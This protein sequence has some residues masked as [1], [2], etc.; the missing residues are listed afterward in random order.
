MTSDEFF[1]QNEKRF[2][3]IFIDGLHEA[4]QV[5]R[6]VKNSLNYLNENG[7]ILLH[8]CNPSIEEHQTFP[9]SLDHNKRHLNIWLGDTWKT[10]TRYLLL[11][12]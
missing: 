4:N 3:L 10:V 2:D 1:K 12:S 11:F 5:F 9:Q 6:D 7:V 8:D